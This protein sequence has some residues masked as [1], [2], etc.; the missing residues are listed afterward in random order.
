MRT[1][2]PCSAA[3]ALT[4]PRALPHTA[5]RRPRVRGGAGRADGRPHGVGGRPAGRPAAAGVPGHSAAAVGAPTWRTAR[6]GS[7]AHSRSRALAHSLPHSGTSRS[8]SRCAVSGRGCWRWQLGWRW[9]P[10]SWRAWSAG[11]WGTRSR[12]PTKGAGSAA[13]RSSTPFSGGPRWACA[14]W[15]ATPAAAGARPRFCTV[16]APGPPRT[17]GGSPR[18]AAGRQQAAGGLGRTETLLI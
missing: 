4:P 10:S 8:T 1:P 2:P 15:A 13:A 5:T 7:L 12:C 14:A 9:A 17:R 11:S 18:L 6:L 16:C 3:C